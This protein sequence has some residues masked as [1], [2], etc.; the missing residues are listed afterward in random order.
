MSNNLINKAGRLHDRLLD[1]V[2]YKKVPKKALMI[3]DS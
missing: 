1:Q 2:R 3:T